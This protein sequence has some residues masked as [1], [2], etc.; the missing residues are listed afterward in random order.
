MTKRAKNLT[1]RELLSNYH[2]KPFASKKYCSVLDRIL[3]PKNKPNLNNAHKP[4][5]L[6]DDNVATIP[7]TPQYSI[8]AITKHYQRTDSTKPRNTPNSR[9]TLPLVPTSQYSK[10]PNAAPRRW[11]KPPLLSKTVL[12]TSS[13]PCKLRHSLAYQSLV[14]TG[15]RELTKTAKY[16]NPDT[17]T[18]TNPSQLPLVYSHAPYNPPS[19]TAAA[20]EAAAAARTPSQIELT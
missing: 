1:T 5:R 11:S 20:A 9:S 7:Q 2:F 3:Q 12:K 10:S 19:V 13:Q 8:Q 17:T 14:K 16:T 18:S 15:S 6:T 4:S